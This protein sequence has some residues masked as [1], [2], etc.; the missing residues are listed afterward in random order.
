M[1][2]AYTDG[3][4][5]L[6]LA[7]TSSLLVISGSFAFSAAAQ[8]APMGSF[9]Q[10][11]GLLGSPVA[12]LPAQDPVL[13]QAIDW[14]QSNQLKQIPK[15]KT[16]PESTIGDKPVDNNRRLILGGPEVMPM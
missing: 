15:M 12:Q 9:D 14:I 4:N 2:G 11:L 1:N 7:I 13:K 6:C 8:S 3:M 10:T 5:K 16:S